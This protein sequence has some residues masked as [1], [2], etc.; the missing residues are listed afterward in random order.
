M[1]H[2]EAINKFGKDFLKKFY[3]QIIDE[4]GSIDDHPFSVDD[5]GYPIPD[6]LAL[7]GIVGTSNM[8]DFILK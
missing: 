4:W 7:Q 8:I 3:F 2:A 1:T 5:E 6:E